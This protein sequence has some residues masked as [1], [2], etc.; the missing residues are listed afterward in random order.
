MCYSDDT[1]NEDGGM[2]AHATVSVRVH[3]LFTRLLFTRV[4]FTRVLFTRLL[5][6]RLLFARLLFTRT[7]P[8]YTSP[9]YKQ[10]RLAPLLPVPHLPVPCSEPRAALGAACVAPSAI[11]LPGAGAKP[12]QPVCIEPRCEA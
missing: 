1:G 2:E 6:A 11:R 9:V 5:F 12:L 10:I 4:L 7:S 3:L 8:V